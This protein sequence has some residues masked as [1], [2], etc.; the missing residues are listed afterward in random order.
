MEMKKKME[1]REKE[2]L[3]EI[4]GMFVVGFVEL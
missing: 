3:N 1:K 2:N 4:I